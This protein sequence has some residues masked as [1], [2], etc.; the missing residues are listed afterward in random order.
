MKRS[1]DK[2]KMSSSQ[3]VSE[4]MAGE[5]LTNSY[6]QGGKSCRSILSRYS[7]HAHWVLLYKDDICLSFYD[8]ILFLGLLQQRRIMYREK[9]AVYYVQLETF[10]RSYRG[11][12]REN[13]IT[14]IA[15]KSVM[16]KFK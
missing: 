11:K 2:S 9:N 14:G 15:T 6:R 3:N 13:R 10:L 5:S 7:A 8:L 12:W 1:E 16:L 4:R